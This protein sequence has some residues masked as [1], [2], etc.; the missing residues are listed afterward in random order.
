MFT[1]VKNRYD[2]VGFSRGLAIGETKTY[3]EAEKLILA[4]AKRLG[5]KNPRVIEDA[6]S[7]PGE[8]YLEIIEGGLDNAA[9]A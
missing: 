7:V 1:I 2:R 9:L 3:G 6:V 4:E 8:V 5:H